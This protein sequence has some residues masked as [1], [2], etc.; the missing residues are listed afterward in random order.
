MFKTA[1]KLNIKRYSK[2]IYI[3]LIWIKCNNKK[4]FTKGINYL[5][6]LDAMFWSGQKMTYFI[7]ILTFWKFVAWGRL[8]RSWI[9]NILTF[10]REAFGGLKQQQ[11]GPSSNRKAMYRLD[12]GFLWDPFYKVVVIGNCVRNEL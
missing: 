9:L 7:S 1:C 11:Y 12:F 2:K 10:F 4:F 6:N 3:Q 5:A 8:L